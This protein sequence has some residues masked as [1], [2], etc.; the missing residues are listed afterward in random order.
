VILIRSDSPGGSYELGEHDLKRTCHT[1][2]DP[3][4]HSE[5]ALE[6]SMLIVG[7]HESLRG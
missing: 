1:T 3:H 2:V 6:F 4:L 7:K 5:Q